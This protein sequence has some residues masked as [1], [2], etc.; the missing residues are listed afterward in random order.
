MSL[1]LFV[2]IAAVALVSVTQAAQSCSVST[3]SPLN[4][5]CPSGYTLI[6]S[7]A[8]CP[9]AS[10]VNSTT[11]CVDKTNAKTGTSDCPG[12]KSYCL[13]SAYKTLMADQCPLTC[14]YCTSTS[15]TTSSGSCVDLLNSKTGKSDCPGMSAYCFNSAYLSLMK[16]QCPK[17]CGYC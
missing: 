14:G 8:C 6:N 9:T 10:V 7:V 4:G 2:G 17:T 16:T 3:S 5:L 13:N 12:M 11:T 15:T 1:G